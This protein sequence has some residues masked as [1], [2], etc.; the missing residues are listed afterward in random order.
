MPD[1]PESEMVRYHLVVSEKINFLSIQSKFD[2][3]VKQ[4]N[5]TGYMNQGEHNQVIMHLQGNNNKIEYFLEKIER[6][7]WIEIIE[8]KSIPVSKIEQTFMV[9]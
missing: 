2:K 4:L 6:N 1:F 9:L 8:K 3:L 7:R 5:F